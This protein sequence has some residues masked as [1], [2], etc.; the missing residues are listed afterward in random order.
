MRSAGS[1]PAP[2]AFRRQP[3]RGVASWRTTGLLVLA[4]AALPLAAAAATAPA[5]THPA[6]TAAPAF[7]QRLAEAEALR[8]ADP[9]RFDQLLGELTGRV[10]EAT[11]AQREQLAYLKAYRLGYTGRFDLAI[12]AATDLFEQSRDP[13][14]RLRAGGLVVSSRA[15]TR[16]F[17]EGLVFLDR[18][19][20]LVDATD[21]RDARHHAWAAAG[22]IHNQVGQYPQA[23]HYVDL[24]MADGVQGRTRC[25]TGV[26]RL[27]SLNFMDALPA[28]VAD[29]Q[30]VVDFCL[31]QKEVML[32]NFARLQLANKLAAD[33]QPTLAVSLLEERLAEI[34]ATGYPRLIGEVH[35]TLARLK[36]SLGWREAAD[37]HARR[38]IEY[39][40]GIGQSPL[41][42]QAHDVL[43]RNA[44]FRGDQAAMLE[45]YRRYAEAD[46][47]YLDQVKARELAYQMARHESL[48]KTQTIALLNGQNEVL[49]LERQVARKTA[50]ANRLLIGLLAL[51]VASVAYWAYKVKRMQVSLRTMAQT[52]A[53]TGA[54]NR[55]YFTLRAEALLEQCRRSGTEAGLVMLD[56]DHFKSINDRF[57]HAAGDWTLRQAAE[58]C[59]AACPAGGLVG[60]LGG[61]EFALLV[62]GRDLASTVALARDCRQRIAA[63]DSRGAGH[64]FSVTASFGVAGS[65]AC[66]HDFDQLLARADDALYRAKRE[67]RDRV[68]VHVPSAL[69]D[70][71]SHATT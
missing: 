68:C 12:A 23:V 41:L 9:A 3:L 66:G 27:E 47:A 49:Q 61:E 71:V 34:E 22:V 62:A 36:Q 53:L 15:A 10:Q 1:L 18:I 55:H 39:S 32:A 2:T 6:A 33:Q 28:D 51:T 58:A 29:I 8:S 52:D 59:L 5:A 37:A 60:R 11:P 50:E 54:S 13:A 42:V 40:G 21:D 14:V 63:I 45:H 70:A 30:S 67:G 57:G 46:R 19:L 24:L 48:Q 43:Y 56:L 38:A 20:P 25:F 35:A 64:D 16:E 7:G 65:H 4:L 31:S 69:A 17:V 44:E 26:L